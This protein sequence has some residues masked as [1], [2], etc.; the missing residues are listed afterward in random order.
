MKLITVGLM[1]AA[2]AAGS[3]AS[4]L[5]Y[6]LAS[7][8]AAPATSVAQRAPVLTSSVEPVAAVQAVRP[9]TTFR[10]A[11]C[12]APA[13]LE[14]GVCVTDVV[15]TVV[16]SAPAPQPA[17]PPPAAPVVPAA[18]TG[19]SGSTS[20]DQVG[21]NDDVADDEVEPAEDDATESEDGPEDGPG[22]EGSGGPED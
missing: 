14:R 1:S 6:Q 10:W 5:T 12:R 19:G 4:A 7:S 11:P 9:G 2:L 20:G 8:V 13:Q 17:A 3:G 16:V 22:D 18:P 15:R 21:P